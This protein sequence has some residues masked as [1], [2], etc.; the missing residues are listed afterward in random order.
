ML[1]RPCPTTDCVTSN[2]DQ[3]KI[4]LIEIIGQDGKVKT[5][6]KSELSSKQN[7]SKNSKLVFL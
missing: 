7:V 4:C 3:S 5:Q 2:G 6:M 1:D